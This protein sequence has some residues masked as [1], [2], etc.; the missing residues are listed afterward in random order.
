MA[1]RTPTELLYWPQVRL[2]LHGDG[3]APAVIH[4][5]GTQGPYTAAS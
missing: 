4:R 2:I 5:L 3:D 1:F